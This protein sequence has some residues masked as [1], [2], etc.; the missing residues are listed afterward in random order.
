MRPG[1]PAMLLALACVGLPGDAMAAER[2]VLPAREITV[3]DLA[4]LDDGQRTRLGPLAIAAIPV[5]SSSLELDGATRAKLLRRRVPG[6]ELRLRHGGNVRFEVPEAPEPG[7]GARPCF[8]LRHNLD[9]GAYL[10]PEA[11]APAPCRAHTARLPLRFDRRVNAPLLSAPLA[12]GTY[13][14]PLAVR[15]GPVIGAGMELHHVARQGPVTI[16]R[17][18]SALQP[19]RMGQAVFVRAQDGVIFASRLV[20]P[21]DGASE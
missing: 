20:A 13:L 16:E 18:V 3:A 2:V 15:G 21:V 7:H 6:Q 11:V 17:R 8:M 12:A 9:A 19:S 4:M 14:G 1:L 10:Q 5:G